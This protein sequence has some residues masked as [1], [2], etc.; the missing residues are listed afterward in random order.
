[1][2]NG[3]IITGKLRTIDVE[4]FVLSY[5]QIWTHGTVPRPTLYKPLVRIARA[6]ER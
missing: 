4:A 2:V 1:M 3:Q 6:L 5:T